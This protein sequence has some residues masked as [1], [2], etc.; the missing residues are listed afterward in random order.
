LNY[1]ENSS[2]FIAAVLLR[3]VVEVKACLRLGKIDRA[4]AKAFSIG[5]TSEYFDFRE[6]FSLAQRVREGGRSG[7]QRAHGSSEEKQARIA[8]LVEAF[9]LAKKSGLSITAAQKQAA[10]W[11]RV[12]V[13]TIQ[14]AIAHSNGG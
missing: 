3:D 12:S 14:R 1:S 4:L 5:Q 13:R 10:A 9:A 11:H 6:D 2:E 8:R 7:S